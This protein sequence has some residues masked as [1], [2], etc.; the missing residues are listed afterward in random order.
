MS[1]QERDRETIGL[2]PEGQRNL[3]EINATGWFS[4]DQDIARLCLALAVRAGTPA[5]SMS[6]TATR[7][8]AGLFDRTGEIRSLLRAVYPECRTPVRLMEYL[9]HEGLAM[10]A[11][12]VREG[13][14]TPADLLDG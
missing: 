7:W 8:S 12:K 4:A 6:D 9:V 14:A 11:P 10:A 1:E 2:T 5:G 3:E 13:G